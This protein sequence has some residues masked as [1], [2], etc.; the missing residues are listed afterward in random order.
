MK[1]IIK[2]V[3]YSMLFLVLGTSSILSQELITSE[4]TPSSKNGLTGF[5]SAVSGG[6]AIVA[7]PQKDVSGEKSLGG[8]T[9]YQ[10]TDGQWKISQQVLPSDI[11]ELGSFG[12]S[13]AIEGNT[14]VISAIGDHQG[15]LFS[16]AVYVYNYDYL[17]GSWIQV[18]K[19]KAS[20]VAIGKRF[21]HSVALKN[22]LIVVGA[23]NA[24]GNELKSGAAYAFQK[25]EDAWIETQKIYA[26][27]GK[28][29]D[30]FG[31]QVHVLDENRIA[32][33]AYNADGA[34]ERSG[35]VYI[36]NRPGSNWVE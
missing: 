7:S 15:G 8:V 17:Q 3:S 13:L 16:G 1:R 27:N 36:F 28:A 4:V 18:A 31:H 33:G 32:I 9:F 35:A 14:A 21:G 11:S 29:N 34:E 30:Y 19:L 12:S 20:D 24:D 26:V 22:D 23:Y 2:I 25:V 6:W 10:L 5:S